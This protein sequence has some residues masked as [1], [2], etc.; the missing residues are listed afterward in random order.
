MLAVLVA[1]SMTNIV[2]CSKTE[3]STAKTNSEAGKVDY[4][5]LKYDVKLTEKTNTADYLIKFKDF[6]KVMADNRRDELSKLK[7][8]IDK[9]ENDSDMNIDIYD[10]MISGIDTEYFRAYCASEYQRLYA[11]VSNMLAQMPYINMEWEKYKDKGIKKLDACVIPD[12]DVLDYYKKYVTGDMYD[13]L[14][15]A[16]LK[17]ESMINYEANQIK[18]ADK[19]YKEMFY[20]ENICTDVDNIQDIDLT[21]TFKNSDGASFGSKK[22]IVKDGNIGER[23]RG[24]LENIELYRSYDFYDG[25]FA[26]V[27][28]NAVNSMCITY[29]KDMNIQ[30][31]KDLNVEYSL[32]DKM[33]AKDDYKLNVKINSIKH[34]DKLLSPSEIDDELTRKSKLMEGQVIVYDNVMKNIENSKATESELATYSELVGEARK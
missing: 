33:D 2:G 11:N 10:N 15:D 1:S 3:A 22:C 29:D 6:C 16:H 20:L 32:C 19:D 12:C 31:V 28:S 24:I 4:S 30:Y 17:Y 23:E 18:D 7:P 5:T 9:G 21:L 26:H 27:A 8:I 13:M 25:E 34:K 14:V